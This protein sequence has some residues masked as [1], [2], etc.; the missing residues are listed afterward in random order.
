MRSTSLIAALTAAAL[1]G[2]APAVANDSA[3]AGRP[4]PGIVSGEQGKRL[5]EE[6]MRVIDVRTPQEFAAGHVPGAV[7]IP[8]DQIAARAAE[9]GDPSKPVL[10]YCRTGRRSGIATQT[11]RS[12]G[13]QEIYDMQALSAWPGEVAR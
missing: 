11:L 6:G 8:F 3:P 13:F 1:A 2:C 4:A 7:N 5:V 10:L 12:L 9:V